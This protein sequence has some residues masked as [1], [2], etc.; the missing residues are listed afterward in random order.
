L[1]SSG[2]TRHTL[3]QPVLQCQ[4][5]AGKR[6]AYAGHEECDFGKIYK[7]TSLGRKLYLLPR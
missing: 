7:L 3:D 2:G 4:H 1:Y 6:F 5:A